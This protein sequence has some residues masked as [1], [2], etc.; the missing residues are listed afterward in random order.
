MRLETLTIKGLLAFREPMTLD[1]RELPPGLVAIVG[2]IG[3]GKTTI[4]ESPV[5]CLFR[6]LPTRKK[7]IF[8]Y[9]LGSDSFIEQTFSLDGQGVYRARLNLDGPR[10]KA[11]AVLLRVE[12]DGSTRAL[13][14]G[15]LPSY[16]AAVQ[17]ILPP[18]PSWLA[19][20]FS[21]QNR[22][23]S[24]ANIPKAE[25]KTLFASFL[26]LDQMEAWAERAKLAASQ[27]QI[28]IDRLRAQREL[29]ARDAGDDVE[30][31]LHADAGRL[32]ADGIVVEDQRAALQRDLDALEAELA[33]LQASAA[34]H[35]TAQ[36]AL[37]R[38]LV[39]LTATSA[40][41]RSALEALE[42]LTA[43]AA[44]ERLSLDASLESAIAVIDKKAAD[45]SGRDA[46]YARIEMER[47]AQVADIE[48]RLANN[49]AIQAD[50][51]PIR[52][53]AADFARLE[54]EVAEARTAERSALADL[55]TARDR[56]QA[57]ATR[58][59]ALVAS[60]QALARN[61][62]GG[63]KQDVDARHP[64]IGGCRVDEA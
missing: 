62:R 11:D 37:D 61:F 13:S 16:D 56:V 25:R 10:R 31:R 58:L 64:A 41:R 20:V 19:S 22:A 2:A 27:V 44:A 3:Q 7:P 39:D 47:K 52:A 12:A 51:M 5:G 55:Q 53:A 54:A 4:L 42:R 60:E 18:L 29:L 35:A 33:S 49:R 24:F 17:A 9:A 34:A 23:G 45:L 30:A 59:T 15:K 26:G 38:V 50:A 6:E 36:A 8:D 1:L 40:E 43:D 14:D 46:A 57:V 28:V 21:S 63:L 48:E 32:Q